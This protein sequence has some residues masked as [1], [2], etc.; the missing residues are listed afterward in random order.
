MVMVIRRWFGLA[1]ASTFNKQAKRELHTWIS[2]LLLRHVLIVLCIQC[3][4]GY[5]LSVVDYSIAKS[6]A[7]GVMVC[8]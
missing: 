4:C 7:S 3:C 8:A 2:L 5:H 1:S 6:V